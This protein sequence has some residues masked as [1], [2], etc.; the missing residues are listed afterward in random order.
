MSE[1]DDIQDAI[2]NIQDQLL[3]LDGFCTYC[4]QYMKNWESPKTD[5]GK[6]TLVMQGINPYTG[7]KMIC[8]R[9]NEFS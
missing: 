8:G 4:M 5:I 9:S 3:S 2:K 1:Y 6:S 7:H